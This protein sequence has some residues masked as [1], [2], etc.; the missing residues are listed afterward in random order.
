MK[1]YIL[2]CLS[3]SLLTISSVV[4]MDYDDDIDY[5]KIPNKVVRSSN[6]GGT[7]LFSGLF[8]RIK[9]K[10]NSKVLNVH[11]DDKLV[12]PLEDDAP[13]HTH[14]LWQLVSPDDSNYYRIKCKYNGKVLNV[15]GDDKLVYPLEDDAPYHTH[16]L[17][18]LVPSDDSNYYRI[19][20]KHN[21]KVLNIHG[22][23]KLVYPIEDDAPYHTHRLWQFIPSNYKLYASIEDFKY[24]ESDISK[25][26]NYSGTPTSVA[27]DLVINNDGD[28]KIEK[29]ISQQI[30]KQETVSWSLTKSNATRFSHNTSVS[31]MAKASFFGA[32]FGG[33]VGYQFGYDTTSGS[34]ENN[35]KVKTTTERYT[36]SDAY[37]I[38]PRTKVKISQMLDWVD[39]V[40]VPFTAKA[41]FTAKA[42]RINTN[43]SIS[44]MSDVSP[45]VIKHF[46]KH[47]GYKATLNEEN[48]IVY[49]TINGVLNAKYGI[50]AYTN[51]TTLN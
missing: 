27:A 48:G 16:R 2:Y 21:G 11:G 14:R 18:Q 13:D 36:I 22:D 44:S 40:S 7:D 42:D 32:K 23:D 37:T 10:H 39:G 34:E 17:W 5:G 8:Y 33:S 43:G 1:K 19:K 47:E 4:A 41:K 50:R 24:E 38:P 35:T 20:C 51:V 3:A 6:N 25:L 12:Y 29:T 45:A 30:E 9:S 49:A 28:I 31:I 15:H 46:L 26:L